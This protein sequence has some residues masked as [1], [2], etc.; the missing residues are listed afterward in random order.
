[1]RNYN[2]R[3]E[4]RKQ[5]IRSRISRYSER[6]RLS[7]FRSGK[8]LYAQIIDDAKSNTIVAVSTLHKDIKRINKS[9]NNINSA[10]RVGE[11]LGVKASELGVTKV[12]FDKGGYKYH[13]VIK[14]VAEAA[15]KNLE[16]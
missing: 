16:F 7:V 14:A 3:F 11:L 4:I 2:R 12:V 8:H 15:R 9:N 1:M 6:L 5:R 10:T 13:G